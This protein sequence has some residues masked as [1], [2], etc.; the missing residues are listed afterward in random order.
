MLSSLLS[1][2]LSGMRGN[3]TA[4]DISSH[5]VANA[6]TQ[7]FIPQQAVFQEISKGGVTVSVSQEAFRMAAQDASGTDLVKEM[8][9]SIQYQAGFDIN[10]K[11]VKTADELLG[12]LINTKA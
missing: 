7:G 6:E 12:T 3:Q 10:A 2:G 8:V 11:M 4:L 1:N 9:Q 5:N